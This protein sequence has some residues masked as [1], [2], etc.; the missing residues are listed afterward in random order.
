[1]AAKESRD[2]LSV[3][4]VRDFRTIE[5]SLNMR[6][7]IVGRMADVVRHLIEEAVKGDRS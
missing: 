4:K 2:N 3:K 7:M 1:L 6:T 5:S